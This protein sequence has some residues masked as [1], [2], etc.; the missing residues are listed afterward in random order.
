MRLEPVL[1]LVP[2]LVLEPELELALEPALEPVLALV[3]V[4][5]LV[6]VPGLHK[7]PP[8]HLPIPLPSPKKI[9]IFYSISPPSKIL[10]SSW[11]TIFSIER[12]HLLHWLFCDIQP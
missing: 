11:V 2:V 5:E 8:N 3:L 10:T 9:T 7:P 1:A 6:L 12:Y 4:L